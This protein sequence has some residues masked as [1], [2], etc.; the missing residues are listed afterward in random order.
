MPRYDP[1][2]IL[3]HLSP[4]PSGAHRSCMT[5]C[6]PLPALPS[7]LP[8]PASLCLL[9]ATQTASMVLPQGLCMCCTPAWNTSQTSTWFIPHFPQLFEQMSPP[10]TTTKPSSQLPFPPALSITCIL[11][12][13]LVSYLSPQL[14]RQ[15]QK[16]RASGLWFLCRIL[17]PSA[18][19]WGCLGMN[20]PL[21]VKPEGVCENLLGTEH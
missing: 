9:P 13:N 21:A 16:G 15:L 18:W 20:G 11:L 3:A 5:R 7:S 17:L 19:G 12:T 4:Q 10:L 14:E 1:R 2:Y 6:P 8:P